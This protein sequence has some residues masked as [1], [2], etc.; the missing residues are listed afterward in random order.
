VAI[1]DHDL[2]GEVVIVIRPEAISLHAQRP[3]GSPRN[4]WPVTVRELEPRM[5]RTLVHVAGPPDLVAAVTP[6]VIAELR[7]TPGT[8]LWASAKALD[9]DAYARPTARQSTTAA[10]D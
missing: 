1:A 7:I 9:L 3:E 8:E 4:V 2:L 5:D 6:S 10:P